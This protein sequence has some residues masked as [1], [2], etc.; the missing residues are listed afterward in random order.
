MWP[1]L[2]RGLGSPRGGAFVIALSALPSSV[3]AQTPPNLPPAAQQLHRTPADVPPPRDIVVPE[4]AWHPRK[5]WALQP[6]GRFISGRIDLGMLFFRPRVSVGY[7]QPHWRW[8]GVEANPIISSEGIGLY[9]G[10]RAALPFIDIRIG[11]RYRYTF[12]RS[13]LEPRASYER[14]DIELRDGP[15]S[16]YL[17]WEVEVTGSLPF[18]KNGQ[19]GAGNIFSEL[20][21]TAVTL[22]KDGWWV[23]EETIRAVFKPPW[24]WRAMVGY[25]FRFLKNGALR[26]GPVVQAVGLPARRFVVWRGGVLARFRLSYNLE[27]RGTF[28]P[29]LWSRDNLGA[30][31]AD[32][33][34]LG[35]RYLWAYQPDR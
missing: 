20:A 14:E 33:F 35:I 18:G 31:G 19:L 21:L 25:M 34:Q 24:V 29:V 17:S 32:S 7:G 9:A 3:A 15:P 30:A 16:N 1:S 12:R 26:V 23:Y 27:L 5:S 8:M 4:L 28:V 22:V 10:F 13:F 11:G 2:L 6:L